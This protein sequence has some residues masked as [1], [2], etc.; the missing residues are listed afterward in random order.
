MIMKKIG[1]IGVGVM[2]KAMTR[3]LLKHGFEVTI[4][5]RTKAK[6]QDLIDEGVPFAPNVKA[7][8]K[9]QDIVITMVGYP[10]DVKEV[11][12][13][14]D[15][16]IENAKNGAILIDMTTSS[17]ELAKE[18]AIQAKAHQLESLD[19]PV[20]GGDTGAKNGTLAIMVGGNKD[21]YERALPVFEAMGKNIVYEGTSGA[22]QHTK[23][24]NQIAL[25]GAVAGVVEA[26]TYAKKAGLDVQT[27]LDTISTGAAGSWQMSNTAPRMLEGDMNPGF[28]IKHM[29][30]DLK[31]AIDQAAQN[32]LDLKVLDTVKDMYEDLASRGME[33]LGTQ[34]LIHY[35]DKK[36][37]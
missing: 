29:I 16:I 7:C 18:I 6:V 17:P 15:G 13:G 30:K 36:A 37:R 22:G 12:F 14:Q 19:A 33:D 3:N 24:A 27:M 4:Y 10:S 31:I 1:F 2:G 34:A 21:A 20:S 32:D 9:D 26:M 25:A 5:T 8:V 23:M 11:Y 35:Y 28:Y